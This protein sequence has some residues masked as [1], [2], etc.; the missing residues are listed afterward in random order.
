VIEQRARRGE[1]VPGFGHPLYRDGDPRAKDL[2]DPVFRFEPR[3]ASVE[4]L[5]ALAEAMQSMGREPPTVDFALV[6]VASALRLPSGSATAIFA[7]GR[8]AGW[9][10]HALEQRNH[11]ETLR[12]RARYVGP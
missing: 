3:R 8:A 5:A 9:I 10:A 4:T 2:L 6:G 11:A 1:A 12:P 7:I